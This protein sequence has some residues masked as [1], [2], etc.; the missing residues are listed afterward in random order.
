MVHHDEHERPM[1]E[2]LTPREEEI[3]QC[4]GDGM[5]NSQIAEH[6]TVSI[7]T[8]KWYV[9]QIY[10]K[11]DVANRGEAVSYAQKF[12]LLPAIVPEG[13]TRHN[14]PLATTPFVGRRI[15]LAA[16]AGLIADPQVSIIT[17]TGPGGIGKTRLALEVAGKELAAAEIIGDRHQEPPFADGIYFVPLAPI[18]S[19]E[20]IVT[21]LAAKL[22]FHFEG[23][24]QIPRTETQQL[25]DYLKHKQMLLLIDNFEQILEGRS[26]L[27]E[28][29]QQAV[30]IK[31]LV[32][33]REQLQLRG[34]QLFPLHGLEMPDAEDVDEDS[35]AG[36]AAAQLFMNISRRVRPD[37]K[38]LQ[39][40]AGQLMRICRL[41]E[42]MP[43]GLELA[44]SWVTVLPLSIIADE[45]EQN[46][47]L[48]TA[49]HY[50]LP[51]RHRSL[52]ATLD[53]SWKRLTP[54]Q[55]LI[56]QKL[57][58]F[59]G[60]FTRTAAYAV[61]GATL[62]VLVTLL[63]K[64]WLSYDRQRD[65]YNIHLLLQ[66]YGAGRLSAVPAEEQAIRDTHCAHFC[67]YLKE[68]EADIFSRRQQEVITEVRGEIENIQSAWYWAANQ[69]DVIQLSQGLNILCHFYLWEGRMKD[70]QF[71]CLL[72]GDSLSRSL[73]EQHANDPRHLALWSQVLAWMTEFVD[74]IAQKEK[75]LAQ[76][77]GVLDSVT[78]AGLDTTS[79]QAFILLEKAEAAGFT[80]NEKAVRFGRLALTLFRQVGH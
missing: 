42:G 35:L 55:K 65:R 48:L 37:F 6:L 32:T 63:N 38:L 9:R 54:E 3:L 8:V 4:L 68:R 16:L 18:D 77:Q 60:G 62:P 49:D 69:G 10:N 40:E 22:G 26:L 70:G 19:V 23:S 75:L 45:I 41:V 66:Q 28:I 20:C 15:E 67:G 79:E 1:A 76:S 31:L 74:E 57:T 58:V 47:H 50:D 51:K 2:S 13:P 73:A 21:T 43:L 7:N 64:S 29:G 71:A 52:L 61:A 5:S 78:P 39:G 53:T 24:S 44:A 27:A 36:Y 33:S 59:R 14:L 12:G 56:L 46:L 17:I 34:E 11:L 30:G 25:I 80:D 72:A